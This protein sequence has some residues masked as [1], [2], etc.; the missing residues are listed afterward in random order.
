MEVSKVKGTLNY[1]FYEKDD[2][3]GTF[4]GDYNDGILKANFLA[5]GEG[6]ASI[7]EV[8]F[9]KVDGGFEEGT[10]DAETS[11]SSQIFTNP[12]SVKF[13]N[14]QKYMETQNCLP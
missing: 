9:K 5:Y 1:N 11:G 14:Q 13:N 7:R 4:E 12:K 3:K 2:S 6:A 10:G 8:I